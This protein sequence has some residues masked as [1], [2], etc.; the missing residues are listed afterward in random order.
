MGTALK[1][2]PVWRSKGGEMAPKGHAEELRPRGQLF[3]K[4][5]TAGK[6]K[7]DL[8]CIFAGRGG[9]NAT[10]RSAGRAEKPSISHMV[11]GRI[12]APALRH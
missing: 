7:R 12:F 1:E 5:T 4:T 2:E 9:R 10:R 11:K 8:L 3:D 6:D